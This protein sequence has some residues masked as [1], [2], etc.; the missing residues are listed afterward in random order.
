MSLKV[1]IA[2]LFCILF[3]TVSKWPSVRLKVTKLSSVTP[4]LK[5]VTVM[6][7]VPQFPKNLRHRTHS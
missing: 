3:L 1:S 4:D 7:K 2:I 6:S 5:I